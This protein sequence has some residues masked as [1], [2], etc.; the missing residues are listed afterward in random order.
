VSKL[1]DNFLG[2]L[3]LE[4]TFDSQIL[5][6]VM[7]VLAYQS[8]FRP[9]FLE[10]QKRKR[11]LPIFAVCILYK[12]CMKDPDDALRLSNC[13]TN[14][15]IRHVLFALGLFRTRCERQRRCRMHIVSHTTFLKNY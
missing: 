8:F 14:T 4:V 2:E 13:A 11:P 6:L 3:T 7:F 12:V 5:H 1:W 10:R 15:A 9:I